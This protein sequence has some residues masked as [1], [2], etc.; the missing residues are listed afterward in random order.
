[1]N[2]YPHEAIEQ[3]EKHRTQ[4]DMD[5]VMVGVSREAV[6]QI[7]HYLRSAGWNTD[8]NA[9]PKDGSS[10]LLATAGGHVGEAV[11]PDPDD[12]DDDWYWRGAACR[13]HPS[14]TPIAWQPLPRHP[15]NPN[16]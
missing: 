2:D 8:L 7:I 1:M 3:V 4:L 13:I 5:G 14:H 11:P 12:P 10:V 6:E 16:D 15:D 9:A